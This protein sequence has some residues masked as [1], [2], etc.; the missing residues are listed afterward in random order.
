MKLK[1]IHDSF[2]FLGRYH[3]KD[4][5]VEIDEDLEY[6]IEHFEIIDMPKEEKKET[7]KSRSKKN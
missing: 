7:N 4:S 1:A 3:D 5:V 6:P 2:G